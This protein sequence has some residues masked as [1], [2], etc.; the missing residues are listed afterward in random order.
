MKIS[1]LMHMLFTIFSDLFI[2]KN[3]I[4]VISYRRFYIKY[5]R[6]KNIITL[7]YYNPIDIISYKGCKVVNF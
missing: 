4:I 7:Q 2:C 6:N 5:I 3:I 1:E